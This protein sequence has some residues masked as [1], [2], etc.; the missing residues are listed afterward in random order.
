MLWVHIKMHRRSVENSVAIPSH[1]VAASE[2]ILCLEQ[3]AQKL[4]LQTHF[5]TFQ[6]QG[7]NILS[8]ATYKHSCDSYKTLLWLDSTKTKQN[9]LSVSSSVHS[10]SK[11]FFMALVFI[12]K[13]LF[14]NSMRKCHQIDW[15]WKSISFKNLVIVIAFC[16]LKDFI[17]SKN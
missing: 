2:P 14:F 12:L 9:I 16:I 17:L 6:S 4:I 11:A 13:N 15:F 8:T 5:P 3:K 7:P 1:A 10:V